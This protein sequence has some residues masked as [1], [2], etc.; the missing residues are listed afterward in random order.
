MAVRDFAAL[1]SNQP[2]AEL[3]HLNRTFDTKPVIMLY[4][5]VTLALVEAAIAFPG[6]A[7]RMLSLGRFI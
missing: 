3:Y 6:M 7:N 2:Q 1:T 4:S 5:F